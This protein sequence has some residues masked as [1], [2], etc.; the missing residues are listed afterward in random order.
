MKEKVE[1]IDLQK[2]KKK[3]QKKNIFI[4]LFILGFI[5]GI[6]FL[7][8]I[9]SE[10]TT[11]KKYIPTYSNEY[12]QVKG[13]F[14]MGKSGSDSSIQVPLEFKQ[15]VSVIFCNAAFIDTSGHQ[16]KLNVVN[17]D[18]ETTHYSGSKI[19][20]SAVSKDKDLRY[21]TGKFV[22]E[23]NLINKRGIQEITT[24]QIDVSE[25]PPGFKYQGD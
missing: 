25:L 23:M 16:Y 3:D 12:Y 19:T 4:G 18:C 7:M 20:Y 11:N 5:V 6:I 21:K 14:M 15:D 8:N 9:N 2:E 10:N 13:I 1:Y 24:L 17:K 22:I